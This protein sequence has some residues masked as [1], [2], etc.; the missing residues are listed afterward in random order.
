MSNEPPFF[1]KATEL[2]ERLAVAPGFIRRFSSRSAPLFHR[3]LAYSRRRP[4]VLL[5]R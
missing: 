2:T 5:Q 3:A 1:L 4:R